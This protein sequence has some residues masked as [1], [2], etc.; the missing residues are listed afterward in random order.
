MKNKYANVH[1][2]FFLKK[3]YSEIKQRVTRPLIIIC[4]IPPLIEGEN[5]IFVI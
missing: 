4:I 1:V 5:S 3:L 2:H